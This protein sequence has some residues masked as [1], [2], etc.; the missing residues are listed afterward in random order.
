MT[1]HPCL[2]PRLC[3]SIALMAAALLAHGCASAPARD[4]SAP[5][6]APVAEIDAPDRSGRTPLIRAARKGKI[7]VMRDLLEQAA[8]PDAQDHERYTA[9]MYLVDDDTYRNDAVALLL[10]H[11][12][13]T[14]L[15]NATGATVLLIAASKECE[16][17][18]AAD[19]ERLLKLLLDGGA[20]ANTSS[21]GNEYPLQLAAGAGQPVPCLA[22]LLKATSAENRARDGEYTALSKAA[23][24]DRREAEA[25][26]V[27][28]GFTPQDLAH[29]P[30][31]APVAK[32]WPPPI[33][34]AV[35]VN[36][37]SFEAY[38]DYLSVQGRRA[39]AHDSLERSSAEIATAIPEYTAALGWY[40]K[41]LA[42]EKA[43][44]AERIVGLVALNAIGAGLGVATGTG[45]AFIPRKGAFSNDI[46]EYDDDVELLKTR[47]ASLARE[48]ASVAAKLAA[49]R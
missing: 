39:Q 11:H 46:D 9:L 1:D 40:Q 32:D 25:Y 17:K 31:G 15:R 2:R 20:D 43:K 36:A 21:F 7:A 33:D 16:P 34:D 22:L 27:G 24:Y 49:P 44:R 3:L 35:V 42:R 4:A 41:A 48:Q 13:D 14:R 47:L 38:G 37:R 23:L 45:V 19:Q 12:A 26:L 8:N 10:E 5:P 18:D 28:E 6:K 29:L 30:P